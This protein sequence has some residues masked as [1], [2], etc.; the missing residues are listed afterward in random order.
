MP[1]PRRLSV[2]HYGEFIMPSVWQP[3]VS[4]YPNDFNPRMIFK[5][6][7][8]GKWI[9]QA[10]DDVQYDIGNCKIWW[11]IDGEKKQ[12]MMDEYLAATASPAVVPPAPLLVD[13]ETNPGEASSSVRSMVPSREEIPHPG[14]EELELF[15]QTFESPWTSIDVSSLMILEPHAENYIP[16]NVTSH[17]LV[18]WSK[19]GTLLA[20]LVPCH[21][22]AREMKKL[23][24]VKDF[25][26]HQESE[27]GRLAVHH[28]VKYMWVRM[29][30]EYN[31][32][33]TS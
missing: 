25:R 22:M 17:D 23:H 32:D 24:V 1:G 14:D 16:R 19:Q 21:W 28:S 12:L 4:R 26:E 29:Q 33:I 20:S 3:L 5:K 2:N 30:L 27:H 10:S 18:T 31:G 13:I 8:H 11:T 6:E 15:F 7:I 9:W